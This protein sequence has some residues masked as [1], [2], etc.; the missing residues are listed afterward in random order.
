MRSCIRT[1]LCWTVRAIARSIRW[2][3]IVPGA[4]GSFRRGLDM[5]K[6]FEYAQAEEI[7]DAFARHGV[8]SVRCLTL[9]AG[10][11]RCAHPSL[12]YHMA[13]PDLVLRNGTVV[14]G[15]GGEPFRADVAVVSG[16]I[17]EIGRA[18]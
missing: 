16:V 2:R 15:S 4:S 13:K 14:D 12:E 6:T 17:S 3:S 9:W 10:A 8:R 5:A 11:R 1:S 7:R 18:S